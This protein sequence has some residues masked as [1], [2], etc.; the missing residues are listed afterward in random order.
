MGDKLREVLE[1]SIVLIAIHEIDQSIYECAQW[2]SLRHYVALLRSGLFSLFVIRIITTENLGVDIVC[3]RICIARRSVWRA[4]IVLW[5]SPHRHPATSPHVQ[6]KFTAVLS[7]QPSCF[8]QPVEFRDLPF[9]AP[10]ES[11]TVKYVN[12]CC[13]SPESDMTYLFM[14]AY[15]KPCIM[16]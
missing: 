10:V 11:Y 6:H 9:R 13:V 12:D 16:I 14:I 7:N 4:C 1:R 3:T 2:I 15:Q 5:P 8:S